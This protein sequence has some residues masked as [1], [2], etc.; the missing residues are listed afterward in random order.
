MKRCRNL[1][2]LDQEIRDHIELEA[3]ENLDRGMMLEEARTIALRKFGNVTL[4]REETYAVWHPAWLEQFV[5][6][7]RYGL[8]TLGRNPGFSSVVICTLALAISMNTAV[9]SVVETVLLRPLPYPNAN[10]LVWLASYDRYYESGHDTYV[11]RADYSTWKD[12][13]HSFEG[14]AAY[15]NQDLT[16]MY[17]A[18]PSQ[19]RVASITGDFWK[20][21][22]AQAAIGSLF[23]EGAPHV[24]VLSH[25]LFASRFNSDPSVLGQTVTING[26]PFTIIGVMPGDFRF[27]FPQ[28]YSTGDE[29]REIDAY[30]AF[31][32]SV[33]RVQVGPAG[34]WDQIIQQV[35]P[36]PYSVRVVASLLPGISIATARTEM[37]SIYD[38]ILR[39]HPPRERIYDQHR[40]WRMTT[41]QQ[42]LAGNARSALMVLLAAVGFVLL[43]AGANIAN[44]LI[45][46]ATTRQRETAIRAAIGAGR[47]RVIRQFVIESVLLAL[48]GGGAGLLLA[49]SCIAFM[50]HFWPQAFPRFAETRIDA[51]ILAVTLTLSC[52]TGIFFGLAPAIL[53]WRG[54]FNSGLKD[55]AHTS[56][57]NA[58]H[59]RLR[60]VLVSAELALAIVLLTGAGLML[61]SF[62][63][64]NTNPPGFKPASTLTLRVSLAGAQYG[65]WPAQQAYV[66]QMLGRMQSYPG[67][68][69][70]GIDSFAMHTNVKVEGLAQ[71]DT[72]LASIR[73]VSAGYLRAMGVPLIAG[74]WLSDSQML[75]DIMVNESFAHSI[76]CNGD[77]VGRH[78]SGNFLSGTI[79][80]VVADF[81]YS[82]LDAEPMPEV[83][84]SYELAP[85][86]NPMSVHLFV[87]MA[88]E[89]RPDARA[90]QSAVAGID[91]TQPVYDVQTLEQA[92]SDSIAPRRL[93][94]FLLGTFASAALL[95]A[96]LGIY[97]VI[98]Y[99]VV[100]RT[101]EIGIRMALG[102]ARDDILS[103]V[104]MEGMGIALGGIFLGL[105][106]AFGL[107]RLMTSLL[108][109]VMPDDPATFLAVA[110]I[111][112]V[113]ALLASLLPA[114][115]AALVDPLTAL[116][117]E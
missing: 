60:R 35:G 47:I 89:G 3:Q 76:S 107:T 82:Q 66:H 26:F 64:M 103:M 71:T 56:T 18:L 21:T 73:A 105:V 70:A 111:L 104:V 109:R 68:E 14:V 81:K 36:T 52:L 98:A 117:H 50:I 86:M 38:R 110:L 41:L 34:F 46:R 106:T 12:Q 93:N 61:K 39:G 101:Q 90:L 40:G 20:L 112:S 16:V 97:G 94:L 87:R 48:L 24:I 44:L 51:P 83:Y 2:G 108:Y 59:L 23:S 114:L 72:S 88:G 6:D 78:I 33:V 9:F 55:N 62:W 74:R 75:D 57:G 28:Q 31:S 96:L 7:V 4:V 58:S 92:L 116:R 5:Q 115:R 22:G 102:A 11:G 99:S 85:L 69:A 10:R 77:V 15:G 84:T 43:I 17:H 54:D 45:A 53:L 1:E 25:A 63:R 95:M 37:D 19:E 65:T 100:Q 13:T 113:T 80:G 29:Q 49:R 32:P 91:P 67:V 27:L 42:K 8:R 79:A 30:I